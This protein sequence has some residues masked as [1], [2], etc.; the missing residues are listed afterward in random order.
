M[1]DLRDQSS[2]LACTEEAH[3]IV[4]CA[5]AHAL[6][7]SAALLWSKTDPALVS[8]ELFKVMLAEGNS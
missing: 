2:L 8:T 7:Q 6:A 1:N 5:V 4:C 3:P